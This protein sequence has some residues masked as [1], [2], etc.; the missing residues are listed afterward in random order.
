ME[1]VYSRRGCIMVSMNRRAWLC[2]ALTLLAAGSGM[3]GCGLR[4]V[5]PP[6]PAA[7]L[8]RAALNYTAPGERFYPT[9]FPSQSVP[10]LPALS[11]TW[12]T[13][14][15]AVEGPGKSPSLE[16]H[17]ISWL[18]ATLD[19]HPLDLSVEPGANLGLHQTISYALGNHE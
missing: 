13:V 18:P 3:T 16:V 11:H 10:R 1:I 14:V 4:A 15:R 19:I 9:V 5:R 7:L 2:G 6:T 12:A 17:T 8:D